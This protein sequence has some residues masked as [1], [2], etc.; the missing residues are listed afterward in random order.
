MKKK[1]VKKIIKLAWWILPLLILFF[2]FTSINSMAYYAD[3]TRFLETEELY[4]KEIVD[5]KYSMNLQ[6]LGFFTS[7]I[8]LLMNVIFYVIMR[9]R[10]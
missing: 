1:I 8:M 3:Q 7:V 4:T 10:E 9:R 2:A 5:L 6:I